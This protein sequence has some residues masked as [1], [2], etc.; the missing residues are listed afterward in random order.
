MT[1][2]AAALAA[3]QTTA[4]PP[5]ITE[6]R[7]P[8]CPGTPNCVSSQAEGKHWIK[9]L[10]LGGD[11]ELALGVIMDTMA[12]LRRAEV[13]SGQGDLVHVTFRSRLGFVDDVHF[14]L[15]RE[16]GVIH[17]RSASRT[18]YS[19]LGVNRRRVERLRRDLEGKI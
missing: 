7:L 19:D 15:D 1:I 5:E 18:G 11:P 16:E 13:V 12:L 8:P 14:L 10:R 6:G 2:L 4:P 9:P 17:V 3:C